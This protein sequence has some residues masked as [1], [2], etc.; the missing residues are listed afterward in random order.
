MPVN[1]RNLRGRISIRGKIAKKKKK[2]ILLGPYYTTMSDD[3]RDVSGTALVI[4]DRGKTERD[5]TTTKKKKNRII[6]IK[7]STPP[8]SITFNIYLLY[9]SRPGR[10]NLSIEQKL[11]I[12]SK[13]SAS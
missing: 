11:Y 1:S 8:S 9:V 5:K 6:K 4:R 3:N 10:K 7:K 2:R 12:V 13:L